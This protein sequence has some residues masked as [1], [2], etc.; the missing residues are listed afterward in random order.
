ML[1][2]I[3]TFTSLF[4][5][6]LP[7]MAECTFSNQAVVGDHTTA[8]NISFAGAKILSDPTVP[9][10]TVLAAREVGGN[11]ARTF[12]FSN[13]AAGDIYSVFP[14]TPGE[15]AEV[16]G[17]KGVKGGPVYE[18]GIPGIGFEFSDLLAGKVGRPVPAALETKSAYGLVYTPPRTMTVWLIKTKDNVDTSFTGN[19]TTSIQFAVG[20]THLVVPNVLRTRLLRVDIAIGSLTYRDTSC[21]INSRGGNT[22]NLPNI[23][24][25]LLKSMPQGAVTGKQKEFTLDITCPNS[26]VGLNYIYW[27][28]GISDLSP[29]ADGV[30]LNSINELSGGAKDVGLIIKQGTKPI[31]FFDYDNDDYRIRNVGKT[32]S[33][34]F[35]ADYYKIT[36]NI[37]VGAVR[38]MMEVIIQ[39]E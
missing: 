11:I 13:C 1:K 25:T 37:G 16:I 26:S 28:N 18:T 27:F 21:E 34:S 35:S 15:A 17:V 24:L 22:V 31:K 4:F 2:K 12:K 6:S 36:N 32:Q 7:L 39:E 5:V 3:I 33:L 23:D 10:G 29:T 9:A 20:P 8:I 19:K 14:I 38:A 30:L